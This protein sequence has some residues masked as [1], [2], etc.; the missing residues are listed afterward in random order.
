LAV[1]F[2][3]QNGYTPAYENNLPQIDHIFPQSLLRQVKTINPSTGRVNVMRYRDAE[4]NQLANCMLLTKEENGASGKG[5][6]PPEQWFVGR[7]AE[8]AYLHLHLIPVDR[9]L[10]KID[11]FEDFIAERKKLIE[12]KF[13]PL[14]V[15]TEFQMQ[16]TSGIVN[17]GKGISS[18][19]VATLIDAGA[20]KD[21]A[22][23]TL[24]YKR[25]KFTATARRAGIELRE[26]V[27]SPSDAAI[28]CYAEMG[29]SRPTENGWRVWRTTSGASLNDLFETVNG[30]AGGNTK[31]SEPDL[32]SGVLKL[33][34]KL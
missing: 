18:K 3:L 19:R 33:Q 16:G 22:L 21:G 34:A 9:S 14:L 1:Q 20:L 24:I 32:V 12:E 27:F 11:R 25:R 29:S 10:W 8:T 7:R 15:S 2:L 5:D 4:R 13:K 23:L 26:G 30:M 17:S 6:T 31:G 28:R